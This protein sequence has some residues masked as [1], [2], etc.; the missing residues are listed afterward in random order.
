MINIDYARP[1]DNGTRFEYA[2]ASLWPNPGTPTEV[3][4]NTAGWFRQAIEPPCP[5]EGKIVTS[6][7]YE[8][9]A[10]KCVAVYTYTDA[11][12]RARVF[13]K[14][15]LY[16]ALVQSDLWDELKSW[17]ESQTFDGINA[18]TAFSLAQELTDAHPMFGRW[19]AAAKTALHVDDATANAILSASEAE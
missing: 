3:E 2:P 12:Q 15:K 13:S 11:P 18:Y 6:R 10:N 14:L 1:T 9:V 4:Y 17:L 8:I 16:V 7:R 5:P 19:F